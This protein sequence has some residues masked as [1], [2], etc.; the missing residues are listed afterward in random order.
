MQVQAAVRPGSTSAE[1]PAVNLSRAPVNGEASARGKRP[2]IGTNMKP[3][4][5][6]WAVAMIAASAI[7]TLGATKEPTLKVGDS[8]PKLQTSKWVQGEP[9]KQFEKDKAYIVEFWATW[10][11]PCR[12]SI[13][14]LNE[15]AQKYKDKGLVVIGQDCWEQDESKVEPFVKQMG[16]KMTYRV[17]LDDKEGS[18]T[19]NMAETWMAAAGR[20]GIPS[21][22]LVDT[23]GL[24]AW[25]GHPMQLK[26]EVIEAVLE[27]KFDVKKAAADY[28]KEQKNESQLRSVWQDLNRAMQKKD[29]SEAESKLGEAEKLMPEGMRDNLSMMR[30]TILLGKD[31]YKAAY[32]VA[33]QLSEANKKNAMLQNQLAWQILTGAGIKE[34]DL[35]LAETIAVRGNEAADG[36]NAAI[37]DT[38]ARALFMNGKKE[39][40]IEVQEQ[41][42]K[43]AD[44]GMKKTLKETLESYKK[45]ELPKA[46]AD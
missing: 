33:G 2:P 42:V 14:H 24:I 28:E 6:T 15:I 32:K 45:G 11:G 27:G 35:D 29:W 20:N 8:A 46:E 34:R 38:L 3:T 4:Q 30:F 12:V 39:K 19:G 26:D 22:F 18:K 10:C 7:P 9:V 1:G 44:D 25:I 40:A 43:A 5:L 16:E 21:A 37:L 13:P 36:K 17:A 41:A 23:K 31:D